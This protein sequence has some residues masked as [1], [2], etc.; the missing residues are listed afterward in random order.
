MT[1][2]H[3]PDLIIDTISFVKYSI[4]VLTCYLVLAENRCSHCERESLATRQS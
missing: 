2:S 1:D 3:H 4:N